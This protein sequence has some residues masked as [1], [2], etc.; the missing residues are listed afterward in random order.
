MTPSRLTNAA[1]IIFLIAFQSRRRR[2]GRGRDDR[3]E[4]AWKALVEF[5]AAQREA[6]NL[7]AGHAGLAQLGEVVAEIGLGAEIEEL[8]A[9]HRHAFVASEISHDGQ[10]RLMASAARRR[11]ARG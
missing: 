11:R 8:A 1:A 6:G 4:Q 2:L 7:G 9:I 5:G 3:I 10:P